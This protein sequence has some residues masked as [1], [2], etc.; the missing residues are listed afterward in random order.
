MIN[1][2]SLMLL[3]A[4]VCDLPCSRCCSG[5]VVQEQ[6]KE[7]YA[8]TQSFWSI[9]TCLYDAEWI[10]KVDDDIYIALEKVPA[11]LQQWDRK[12]VGEQMRLCP[13]SA[14]FSATCGRAWRMHIKSKQNSGQVL[15]VHS[16]SC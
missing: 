6:Y 12:A 4:V 2:I 11:L 3:V 9:V 10:V 5:H 8:K 13:P 1:D 15:G 14:A 16:A 7:L